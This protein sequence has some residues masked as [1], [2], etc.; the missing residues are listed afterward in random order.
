LLLFRGE[1]VVTV[2]CV[3]DSVL[4]LRKHVPVY[5]QQYNIDFMQEYEGQLI[6]PL[7]EDIDPNSIIRVPM[8]A[9]SLI[10]LFG[11][12]RFQYE[13]SVLREDIVSRRVAI[14]YR[15]FTIPYQKS[16]EKYNEAEEIYKLSG[17]SFP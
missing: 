15:E 12:P 6:E 11:P 14:A 7:Q 4:T 3:G 17:L 2:N 8:P 9:R 5:P 16:N 13:H 1:R 10:V